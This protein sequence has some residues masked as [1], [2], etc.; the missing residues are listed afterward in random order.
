MVLQKV[1]VRIK[2]NKVVSVQ[3]KNCLAS[4]YHLINSTYIDEV[5]EEG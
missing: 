4:K 1:L 3:G 5:W 2:L